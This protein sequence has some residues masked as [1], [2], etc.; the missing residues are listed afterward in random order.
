M[1][2]NRPVALHRSG[3]NR[4]ASKHYDRELFAIGRFKTRAEFEQAISLTGPVEVTFGPRGG[5]RSARFGGQYDG[6]AIEEETH[7]RDL[8]T[9]LIEPLAQRG[10]LEVRKG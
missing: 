2:D 9:S 7:S 3:D 1:D 4:Q 6:R 8:W 5:F 10:G